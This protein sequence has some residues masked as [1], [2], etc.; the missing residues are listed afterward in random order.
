MSV[1]ASGP[2][3]ASDVLAPPDG[4]TGDGGCPAALYL[5]IDSSGSMA[6]FDPGQMIT[7]WDNLSQAIPAFV[8]D[9]THAGL[10]I[11]LDFFPEGGNTPSCMVADYAMPNVGIDVIPGAGNAQSKAIRDAVVGRMVS[12]GTPTTQALGGALQT[13][14]AWQIA[15]PERTLGVLFMTDGQPT[16][17]VAEGN[18]VA[19]AAMVAQTYANDTPR[20]RTFVV[21]VGPDT[22]PLDAIAAGGGTTKAYMVTSGGAADVLKALST[23]AVAVCGP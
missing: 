3:V 6:T 15:H 1:D 11:G 4:P 13:A 16:G 22:G 7:R 23:I 17:C 20:V 12:G 19:A 8:D 21:G 5:M 14:K 10:M 9:P 18:T 2:D